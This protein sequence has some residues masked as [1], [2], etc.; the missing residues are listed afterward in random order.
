MLKKEKSNVFVKNIGLDATNLTL[1]NMFKVFGEIFSSRLAQNIQGRSKGYG[2]VQYRLESDALRA[3]QEMN[4]KTYNNKQLIVQPYKQ[5]NRGESSFNNLYVKS[6]PSSVTDKSQLDKLF[7]PFGERSSVALFHKEY[8]GTMGYFGFVNFI[9][10]E[11][12]TKACTEMNGK[13]IEDSKL[14]VVKALTKEQREREHEKMKIETKLKQRKVTLHIRTA[15]GNP[16]TEDLIKGELSQFGDI[17]QV[18][19]RVQNGQNREN[20]PIG[21]VV[22]ASEEQAQR[23]IHEYRR[24]DTIIISKLE[25]KEERT[26][27]I[28]Q[29]RV[30]HQSD[31]SAIYPSAIPPCM[32]PGLG[33]IGIEMGMMTR[34]PQ[35]RPRNTPRP[36]QFPREISRQFGTPINYNIQR[37]PFEIPSNNVA[38]IKNC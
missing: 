30:S 21:F 19:I 16:L 27:R 15:A 9:R 38:I 24:T 23:A 18:S 22:F 37:S 32:P 36:N 33:R 34:M 29:L 11:D 1:Y 12:A 25:G 35:K 5:K 2:F 10:N 6:L 14:Y 13:T 26:E 20:T 17:K 3:V 4:G 7:E 28:R 8:K 31:Y